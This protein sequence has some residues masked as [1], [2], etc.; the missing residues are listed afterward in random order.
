MGPPLHGIAFGVAGEVFD[1]L[2]RDFV[3]A[4]GCCV[5]G[6]DDFV[7]VE[8]EPGVIRDGGIYLTFERRLS[9][10]FVWFYAREFRGVEVIA[11]V[12]PTNLPRIIVCL[13]DDAFALVTAH[14]PA[15]VDV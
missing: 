7:G 2:V 14:V 4:L 1:F 13:Y 8:D 10:A 11:Q 12:V 15:A 6:V 5:R 9:R 3:G